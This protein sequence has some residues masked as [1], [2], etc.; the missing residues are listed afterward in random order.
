[1]HTENTCLEVFII[2]LFSLFSV[3]L[4][5]AF[6][7]FYS[8]KQKSTS[9]CWTEW[10]HKIKLPFSYCRLRNIR[11]NKLWF[12]NIVWKETALPN[13]KVIALSAKHS[14]IFRS[15][16]VGQGLC[17]QRFVILINYEWNQW[18]ESNCKQNAYGSTFSRLKASAFCI[19]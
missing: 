13:D 8:G 12:T 3:S 19:W 9:D 2:A 15:H 18:K 16:C 14:F 10:K 1:M 6:W 5:S 17:S 4:F 11:L 7:T